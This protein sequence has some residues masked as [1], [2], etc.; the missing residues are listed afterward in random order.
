MLPFSFLN[1][2][3]FNSRWILA[4]GDFYTNIKVY[5]EGLR[6]DQRL[7]DVTLATNDGQQLQA[8]KM[9]LSAG[10]NFFNDIF[11]KNNQ[12]NMLIYLK[13]LSKTP[14]E[15]V[16]D[17]LYKG[18]VYIAQEQLEQFL[19]AGKE[20]QIK[21]LLELQSVPENN[22][23]KHDTIKDSETENIILHKEE[24]V[25]QELSFHSAKDISD[26]DE[27]TADKIEDVDCAKK[28][29]DIQVQVEEMVEK[30]EGVWK[31]KVCGKTGKHKGNLQKH[32]E[33][34]IDGM[35]HACNFCSRIFLNRPSLQ[36]HISGTHTD[37][38]NCEFCGRTG[39]N[40]HMYTIHKYRNHK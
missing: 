1:S 39:M 11:L 2:L 40:K 19:E 15:H 28:E 16:I 14:L 21:G 30:K 37:L 33:T 7:S 24:S 32:V 9:I 4:H 38:I 36:K 35:S 17:F 26:M 27:Y 6:V 20:L 5:F 25:Q 10:S 13:G 18:E 34:H 12:T 3:Y 29:M 31:C 22:L 8:H 23:E